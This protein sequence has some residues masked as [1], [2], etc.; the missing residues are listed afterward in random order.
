MKGI[1]GLAAIVAV[2]VVARATWQRA[3]SPQ[4]FA[5]IDEGKWVTLLD[6]VRGEPRRVYHSAADALD[7]LTIAPGEDRLAFIEAKL[8]E[9]AHG[10][11]PRNELVVISPDGR[12]VARIP[13][14]VQ[15][16]VWCGSRCLAYIVGEYY[17]GGVGFK[18]HGVF[19]FDLGPGAERPVVGVPAPYDLTWAPFDSS[20]Y[21]K[22]LGRP[23]GTNV[24]RLTPSTGAVTLTSYLDFGFCPSGKYY[25]RGRSEDN[26]TTRL[27]ETR[28][29]RAIALPDPDAVGQPAGWVFNEGEFLLLA[30]RLEARAPAGAAVEIRTGPPAAVEY[31]V[32][33]V[34]ARRA[35]RKV[36]G[37]IAP[38]VRPR[39]ALP[40][41]SGGRL[42]V[43][44]RP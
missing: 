36:S 13:K 31:T 16:Y 4:F 21:V 30:R 26:D 43:L 5:R 14:N 3:P 29:N 33:D 35:V 10:R 8:E 2:V 6:P 38:W 34:T 19:L 20:V 28:T 39:G 23:P 18:A 9:G 42:N 40:V 1:L 15:R 32:Y 17:E 37:E 22:S 44:M 24:Y 27:Y 41:L 12:V 7:A 11:V 25:L